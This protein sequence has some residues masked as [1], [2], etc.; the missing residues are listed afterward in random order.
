MNTTICTWKAA[1]F[2]T[3]GDRGVTISHFPY[4]VLPPPILFCPFVSRFPPFIVFLP[5]SCKSRCLTPCSK[6]EC[7]GQLASLSKIKNG[8][9]NRASPHPPTWSLKWHS[10]DTSLHHAAKPSVFCE[11]QSYR[12]SSLCLSYGEFRQL[13]RQTRYWH[14][15]HSVHVSC[16]LIHVLWRKGPVIIYRGGGGAGAIWNMTCLIF[17]DPSFS[18]SRTFQTPLPPSKK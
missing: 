1:R 14:N 5:L 9:V 11:L 4:P 2:L 12:A 13:A 7:F 15:W 6:R 18:L 10:F 17:A 16:Y 8:V 3:R